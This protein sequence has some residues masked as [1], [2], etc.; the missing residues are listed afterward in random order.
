MKKENLLITRTF[1]SEEKKD[2]EK[3]KEKQVKVLGR[4]RGATVSIQKWRDNAITNFGVTCRVS[5]WFGTDKE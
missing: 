5:F 4:E 2:N 3:T 1:S